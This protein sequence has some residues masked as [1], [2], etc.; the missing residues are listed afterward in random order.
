MPK[1]SV[2]QVFRLI[3]SLSKAEKRNFRLYVSRTPAS[4]EARFVQLFDLLEKMATYEEKEVL[5]KLKIPHKKKS[6]LHNLKRHLYR[7]LLASLRTI[8]QDKS[9][10]I[11]LRELLDFARILYDKGMYMESLRFLDRARTIADSHQQDILHLEILEFQ[12]TIEARHITRSRQLEKKMDQLLTDAAVQSHITASA[13]GLSNLN[14]QIQ[15]FYID[16]GHARNAN[17]VAA[18]KHYWQA[19]Q[20]SMRSFAELSFSEQIYWCQARM[21]YHYIILHLEAAVSDAAEL[22]NL[23]EIYGKMKGEDP[24]LYMR[25]LYY[26]LTFQFLLN[27]HHEYDDYL[28]KFHLFIEKYSQSFNDLSALIG[29]TYYHLSLLNKH[30]LLGTYA[31]GLAAL[32]GIRKKLALYEADMDRHRVMLFQ[33][34]FAYLHFAAGQYDAAL[35][36]VNEILIHSTGFLRDD[37]QLN[38]RLLQLIC[39][40]ELNNLALFD[41]L[42]PAL[43]RLVSRSAE[44]SQIHHEALQLLRKLGRTPHAERIP[45][46]L[47]AKENL[48]QLREDSHER[49]A[50]KY[51][52][53][54]I[55]IDNHLQEAGV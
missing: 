5:D 50:L 51:F 23:F 47:E 19:I 55:W 48:Q 37:I 36:D 9:I 30:F 7:Q 20:P 54:G 8:Y 52:D 53:L 43:Q 26:L 28:Q 31:A 16:H 40:Y 35:D 6:Q 1:A 24:D 41:Y 10:D 45:L 25:A 46:L 18:V 2:D 11:Q 44:T 33:Y 38:A 13:S 34:K 42:L 4:K 12:K 27:R 29:F 49:K 22:V 3:K 21:W 39:H 17:E 14:I 32:P 15:G